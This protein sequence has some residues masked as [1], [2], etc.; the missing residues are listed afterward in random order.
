MAPDTCKR[1]GPDTHS[2]AGA[3]PYWFPEK[4]LNGRQLDLFSLYRQVRRGAGARAP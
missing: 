4:K 3:N 1:L 2:T